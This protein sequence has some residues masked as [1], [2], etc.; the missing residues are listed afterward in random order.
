VIDR[1]APTRRPKGSAAGTQK[2]R[3]L[4]FVHYALAPEIVR[5]LVPEPLGLDLWEGKIHVGLVPF[6]MKDIR[7]WWMPGPTAM[8]FLETNVRTYVVHKDEPGVFFFS[9]EASSWL[10]VQVARNVWGLPYHHATMSTTGK[11]EYAS[12]RKSDGSKL[13]A[14][15]K[16]G[17][18]LGASKP[19]T[20]EHFVLERYLLFSKHADG[21]RKGQVHHVPY[22][23]Q[24]VTLERF[25]QSLFPKAAGEPFAAHFSEGVDVEVFGP[26]RI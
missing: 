20:Y 22:P 15:W 10:A 24:R 17:D 16:L 1:I 25:E 19:D 2:W 12:T 13:D 23:A 14:K 6:E 18:K 9:L 5:P 21:L 11:G 7:S 4:L 8:N 26:W 3:N